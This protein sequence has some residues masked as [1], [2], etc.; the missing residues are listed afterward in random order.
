MDLLWTY[1]TYMYHHSLDVKGVLIS[2]K[3]VMSLVEQKSNI[4]ALRFPSQIFQALNTCKLHLVHKFIVIV[5][6]NVIVF[7]IYEFYSNLEIFHCLLIL[8]IGSFY[9]NISDT[10][11]NH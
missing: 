7:Y 5:S 9:I 1:G 4:Y 11:L 10:Y 6:F 3:V 8:K 2:F